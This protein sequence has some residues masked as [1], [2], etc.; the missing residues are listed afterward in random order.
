ME[1][2]V[3]GYSG[4]AA[5]ANPI[6][7]RIAFLFGSLGFLEVT[8][9][10]PPFLVS[11]QRHSLSGHDWTVLSELTTLQNMDHAASRVAQFQYTIH[12]HGPTIPTC[13]IF[14]SQL[15]RAS[16]TLRGLPGLSI[17]TLEIMSHLLFTHHWSSVEKLCN[18]FW[19]SLIYLV[20]WPIIDSDI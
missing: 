3:V 13:F 15:E 18:C 4:L 14:P 5:M 1:F 2:I 11:L 6:V 19:I 7:A 12:T 16:H 17:Q 8:R 10:L 20:E 9:Y